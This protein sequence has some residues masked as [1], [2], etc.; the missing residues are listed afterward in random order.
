MTSFTVFKRVLVVSLA[1][2]SL[3]AC[4]PTERYDAGSYP[5]RRYDSGGEYVYREPYRDDRYVYGYGVRNYGY[6]RDSYRNRQDYGQ[7]DERPPLGRPQAQFQQR[8]QVAPQDRP[9]QQRPAAS[10]PAPQR[11]YMPRNV[12]LYRDQGIPGGDH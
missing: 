4:V 9:Y 6:G 5:A 8:P 11:Q 7:R 12:P 1:A 2:A 3:A 10:A